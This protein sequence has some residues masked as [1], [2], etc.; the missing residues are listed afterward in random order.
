MGNLGLRTL[1]EDVQKEG[2][3]RQA[4]IESRGGVKGKKCVVSL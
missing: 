2:K 1:V 3:A 4:N